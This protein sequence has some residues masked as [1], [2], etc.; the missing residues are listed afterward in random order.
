MKPILL[1]LAAGMGSR[2]GGL[3]QI[4]RI[5]KGGEA[6]FL[7]LTAIF[8]AGSRHYENQRIIY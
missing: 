7:S 4:D 5:G 3:K 1:V 2:Y 8:C 6:L